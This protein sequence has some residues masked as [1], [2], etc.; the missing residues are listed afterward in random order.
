MN[1]KYYSGIFSQVRKYFLAEEAEHVQ[2]QNLY[3]GCIVF[4]QISHTSLAKFN[5]HIERFKSYKDMLSSSFYTLITSEPIEPKGNWYSGLE[6][7][8]RFEKIK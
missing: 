7:S 6:V 2:Y 4:K 1:E 3:L 8:G 5:A